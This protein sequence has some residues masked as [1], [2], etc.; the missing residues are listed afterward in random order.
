MFLQFIEAV[1]AG[2]TATLLHDLAE[3]L[4]KLFFE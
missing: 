3:L 2:L 1:I 4:I